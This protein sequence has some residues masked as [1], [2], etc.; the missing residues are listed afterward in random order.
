MLWDKSCERKDVVLRRRRRCCFFRGAAVHMLVI[1]FLPIL[2]LPVLSNVHSLKLHP[3]A[4]FFARVS[5]G[6]ER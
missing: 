3:P 1:S 4:T 6:T 5:R 2:L